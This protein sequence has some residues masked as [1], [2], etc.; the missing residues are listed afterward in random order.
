MIFY[1][2]G[3]EVEIAQK[4]PEGQG[5]EDNFKF[6]YS[7]RGHN[8]SAFA[9]N[10]LPDGYG[11][12][13]VK[14]MVTEDKASVLKEKYETWFGKKSNR[15]DLTILVTNL[16]AAIQAMRMMGQEMIQEL[17]KEAEGMEAMEFMEAAKYQFAQQFG[18][19]EKSRTVPVENEEEKAEL[20]ALFFKSVTT[21]IAY[22]K[23]VLGKIYSQTN[24][25][26]SLNPGVV[27][28]CHAMWK[29]IF[30]MLDAPGLKIVDRKSVV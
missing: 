2:S 9:I 21:M 29:M 6:I 13:I 22:M 27:A 20:Q 28:N 25:V 14:A 8:A 3:H 5:F 23:V 24:S 16:L 15:S 17:K 19:D 12:E 4:G 30:D 7:C 26:G 18:P 1:G 11:L 10:V